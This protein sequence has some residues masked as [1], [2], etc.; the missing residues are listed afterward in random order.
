VNILVDE[1]IPRMSVCTLKDKGYDVK[2]IRGTAEEGI[3]D[4]DIWKIV[5]DEARLLIATDKGFAQYKYEKHPGIIIIRLRQPNRIRIHQRIL[6][7]LDQFSTQEWRG[8]I[9]VM[10]DRVQSLFDN[11]LD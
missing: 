11:K 2:D 3:A 6:Q 5:C 4:K 1:N 10:R 7:G 9:L 8:K